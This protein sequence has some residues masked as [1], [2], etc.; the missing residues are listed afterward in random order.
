[1][2]NKQYDPIQTFGAVVR[3]I[4][5][6]KGLT[7]YDLWDTCQIDQSYLSD[8]ERGQRNPSLKMILKIAYGLGVKAQDL[9]I[10]ANL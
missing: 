8:I 6:E 7:Q 2:A 3:S 4:R 10:K 1:M 9:F 5:V